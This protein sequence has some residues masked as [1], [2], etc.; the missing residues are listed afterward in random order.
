[1]PAYNVAPSAAAA[2][3]SIAN[4]SFADLELIVVDDGSTDGTPKIAAAA[5][6]PRIRLIRLPHWSA[7]VALNRGLE[8]ATGAFVGFLDGDA[9]VSCPRNK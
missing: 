4:Q 6:D 7:T 2:V 5:G 9:L 8:A 3:A 1:M